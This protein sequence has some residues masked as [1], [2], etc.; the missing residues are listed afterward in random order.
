MLIIRNKFSPNEIIVGDFYAEIILYDKNN[1]EK[2]RAL[3]DLEDVEKC[4]LYKWSL[5]NK[6]VATRWDKNKNSETTIFL[7]RYIMNCPEEYEV[8]H[9]NRNKLDNRKNNLRI[10][11]H[12]ENQK[13]M[14]VKSINKTSKYKG[15]N[16]YQRENCWRVRI[17][18]DNKRF[19]V[20]FFDSEIAAA[21]AY[22]YYAKKF[23]GEFALLNDVKFMEKEEWEKYKRKMDNKTGYKGVSYVKQNNKYRARITIDKK[24]ICLGYFDTPKEASIVYNNALKNKTKLEVDGG[25]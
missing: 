5:S 13:N 21:N 2:A 15:V 12:I 24:E 16:W 7:H 10:C 14:K 6:Y 20:G 9:I 11:L 18:T 19:E 8:D 23:H 17:C 1:K 25:M 4:R 22:N 3:I